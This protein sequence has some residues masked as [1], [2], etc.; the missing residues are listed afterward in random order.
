MTPK[1]NAYDIALE[2]VRFGE[3]VKSL[4]PIL[5]DAILF[6]I[7]GLLRTLTSE[8]QNSQLLNLLCNF[9]VFAK[10]NG[11]GIFK[12]ISGYE[13]IEQEDELLLLLLM[14]WE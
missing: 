7:V 13:L 3:N 6:R 12:I 5:D 1:F 8:W 2:S 14:N 11:L 9:K 10:L 4:F